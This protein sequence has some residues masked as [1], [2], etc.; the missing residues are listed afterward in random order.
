MA[1]YVLTAPVTI[2]AVSYTQ[3]ARVLPKGATV[4][5]SSAEVTAI[6]AGNLRSTAPRDQLGE[7]VGVSN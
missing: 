7:G 6:G 1:R 2:A 3:P 5:L 4:E